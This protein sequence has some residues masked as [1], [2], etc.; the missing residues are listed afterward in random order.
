MSELFPEET[1]EE[2]EQY[3]RYVN[4]AGNEPVEPLSRDVPEPEDEGDAPYEPDRRGPSDRFFGEEAEGGPE[5]KP[6]RQGKERDKAD[7]PEEDR[8][9]SEDERLKELPE[10]AAKEVT[11]LRKALGELRSERREEREQM[12]DRIA[13]L[14]QDFEK[15]IE[16]IK[17]PAAPPPDKEEDPDAYYAYLERE[18]QDLKSKTEKQQTEEREQRQKADAAQQV[19]RRIEQSEAAFREQA[20]DYDDAVNFAIGKLA[21]RYRSNYGFGEQQAMERARYDAGV[22]TV[23]VIQNGGDPAVAAYN[24]ARELGWG[25]RQQDQEGQPGAEKTTT[26]NGVD[27]AAEEKARKLQ[28]GHQASRTLGRGGRTAD[29]G[30]LTPETIGRIRDGDEFERKYDEWVAKVTGRARDII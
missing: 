24:K 1:A 28:R 5:D 11:G 14:M 27:A 13:R 4:E 15:K 9:R 30:D 12:Q 22:F 6:K 23:Q 10:W 3:E 8:S 7:K 26:E 19:Q 21:E 18:Y 20:S 2:R 25:R 29:E 16:E 17:A